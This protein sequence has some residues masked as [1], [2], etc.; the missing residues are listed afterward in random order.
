MKKAIYKVCLGF[1][2]FSLLISCQFDIHNSFSGR[3]NGKRIKGNKNVITEEREVTAAFNK[4]SVSQG[5]KLY[6]KLDE[7]ASIHVE[8]DE[9]L[10]EYI[11]TEINNGALK[12]YVDGFISSSKAKTV[13]V[14]LPTINSIKASSGSAAQS[15]NL[16]MSND[17]H[18]TSS[19]GASIKVNVDALKLFAD[20]SSGSSIRIKGTSDSFNSE[21][22][23]GGSI[24]SYELISKK[25]TARASSGST[26]RLQ[27]TDELRP[28][29]SSGASIR[30]KGRPYIEDFKTSYGG[31]ISRR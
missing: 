12:I 13:Y 1:L 15:E 24:H 31:S 16:L 29:A 10:H 18:L 27:V 25:A 9:N 28:K 22:S 23:S 3:I 17:L 14:A 2:F 8:A 26:I 19:S 4:I 11:K 6:V 7:Q 5:I 20:S 21:S 30:Y